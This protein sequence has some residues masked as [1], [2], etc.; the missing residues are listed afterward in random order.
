MTG[1]AELREALREQ[2]AGQVEAALAR[3]ERLLAREPRNVAAARL[4]ACLCFGLGR[5]EAALARYDR[6]L[7]LDP[8]HA[9]TLRDR[10][11]TLQALS[12]PEDSLAS[13]ERALARDPASAATWFDRANAL[14]SL[15]RPEEALASLDRALA[16]RPADPDALGNRGNV[17]HELGHLDEALASYAQ[18]LVLRP[19]APEV[20]TNRAITLL[21]LGRF[22]EGFQAYEWRRRQRGWVEPRP[23]GPEWQGDLIAGQRLLLYAEQ[24]LGDTIQFV[25]FARIAAARGMEV[26]LS[27]QEPLRALLSGLPFLRVL[28]PDEPLPVLHAHAPLMSLP[29]LLRLDAADLAAGPYLAAQPERVAAWRARLPP[30]F[31][32][33]VA[34]Q[35]QPGRA[36]D[37][38]RSLPLACLAPLARVPGVRLVSLQKVHGLDQLDRLPE[39][40]AVTVLPDLDAGPD[41]FLDTAAVMMSLDLVVTS[42]TAVAHV[43]GALGRPVFVALKPVPDWRWGLAGERTAWYPTMRLFRQERRGDWEAMAAAMAREV[44]G[45]AGGA[46]APD[47]A[48][49]TVRVPVSLGELVDKITILE[50]KAERIADPAKRANVVRELALLDAALAASGLLSEEVAALQTTLRGINAELWD[51]EGRIRAC[52]QDAAARDELVAL[53]LRISTTN[54]RRS[55]VKREINLRGGSV[56]IEEKQYR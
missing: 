27:V 8:D 26:V 28:A 37:R 33:G 3:C 35:G 42:D 20:L 32:V 24:G 17:L 14:V 22:A 53:A 9:E 7:A 48:P 1:A 23:P 52:A 44:A 19:H 21:T 56:L 49:G 5:F 31:R 4:A 25:R 12:R 30:G 47:G 45:L 18:S 10:G 16:L 11:V 13:L 34:W 41:A 55:A 54:E 15:G 38:G 46:G 39:G 43:A 29:R 6:A 36:I 51:A 2:R 50:L 40:M